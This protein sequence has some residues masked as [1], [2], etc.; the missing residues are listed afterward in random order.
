MFY[1]MS[2]KRQ[3]IWVGIQGNAD[4]GQPENGGFFMYPGD[5][6]S[7]GLESCGCGT[8]SANRKKL[9]CGYWIIKISL[10]IAEYYNNNYL[11]V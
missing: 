8:W 5:F 4:M 3:A 11:F 6:V 9:H 1:M 2:S 10:Y 7:K